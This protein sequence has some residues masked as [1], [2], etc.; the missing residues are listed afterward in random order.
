[1]AHHDKPGACFNPCAQLIHCTVIKRLNLAALITDDVVMVVCIISMRWL[2]PGIPLCEVNPS[3]KAICLEEV[4]K[5]VGS[6]EVDRLGI[7]GCSNAPVGVRVEL[8]NGL[9]RLGLS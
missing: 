5:P 6:H 9:R 2:I 8:N 4:D 1:M 3:C 7:F